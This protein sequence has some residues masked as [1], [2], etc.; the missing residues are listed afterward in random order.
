MGAVNHTYGVGDLTFRY[1]IEGGASIPTIVER[2]RRPTVVSDASLSRLCPSIRRPTCDVEPTVGRAYVD[3][4][5]EITPD[6]KVEAAAFGTRFST[7]TPSPR[8]GSSRGLGVAWA[9]V[10]G[11]WLRAGFMR[12]SAT[13]G[14][15]TLSPVAL[16]GLQSNQVPL[17]LDGYSDTFIA[18]WDAEWSSH[19]FTIHRLPAPGSD[20]TFPIPN[21]GLIDTIHL[22]DGSL[23]RVS[24]TANVWLEHGFGVF[25]TIAYLD[26]QNETPGFDGSLPFVPEIVGRV[27]LTWVN[28]ANLKVTLAATYVGETGG[29]PRR[30]EAGRLLDCR[31]LPGLG[32]IRQALR[33]RT[34]RLQS[35]RPGIRTGAD[36]ARLGPLLR[37][38]AEGQVL[39]SGRLDACLNT[40]RHLRAE[41]PWRA[42]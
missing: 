19:F 26:S 9:P 28:E 11:H 15:P 40:A 21:P 7:A 1:G 14:T 16:L 24:A 23:D 30:H 25:G 31:C 36:R 27:G 12:E 2:L 42:A 17:A 3:A 22:T 13:F 41:L 35:L 34:R 18:R 33:A 6:L 37:R 38:I 10:E 5:Y 8:T 4:L 39:M 20:R 29:R 32:T